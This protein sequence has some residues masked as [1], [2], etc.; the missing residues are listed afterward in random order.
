MAHEN[1]YDRLNILVSKR[2]L[3]VLDLLKECSGFGSRGRTIE[4]AL[5]T[6]HDLGATYRT[7]V[8][9]VN[10]AA[11]KGQPTSADTWLVVITEL[12]SKLGRFNFMHLGEV[13]A[14]GP[15]E[16]TTLVVDGRRM[17]R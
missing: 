8:S 3:S 5:L 10:K 7:I 17:S 11:E 6:I 14:E 12:V 13:A 4:E 2:A 9:I 16:G 1:G 15:I